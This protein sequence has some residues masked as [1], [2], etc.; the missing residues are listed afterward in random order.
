MM[1]YI[2]PSSVDMR[3]A[4]KDYRPSSAALPL[5]R[6]PEGRG[7]YSPSGIWGDP[8]LATRAKG[9][10]LVEALVG[11]VLDD[12]EAVRRAPLPLAQG[13]AVPAAAS[14]TGGPSSLPSGPRS[15]TPGDD[16][17]IRQI[18]D[19]YTLAW[20]NADAQT[21]ASLWTEEG[22]MFHPDGT[23]ERTRR[24]ILTNRAAMFSRREYRGSKHP[25]ALTMIR[26]LNAD[27]AVADGKWEMKNVT[28][29][30]GRI[31]PPFEG[32]VTLVVQR[33]EGRWKIE[34]YR[35]TLKPAA[36]APP[37]FLKR[38]GW[39]GGPGG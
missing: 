1:L 16:R 30:A 25:L 20:S 38:P 7:T 36:V 13:S 29:A 5:T 2:D 4:V 37:A 10:V 24:V 11:G 39:P 15:C 28:D 33:A 35:F 27:V 9:Q 31:L 14:N 23:I 12:I 26:C 18:G 22:D 6:R 8:T 3:L 19:A 21:L 17:S 32:Q 34:A